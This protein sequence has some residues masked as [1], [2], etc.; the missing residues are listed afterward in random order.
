MDNKNQQIIS[1]EAPEYKHYEKNLGWY[2][3]LIAVA[4]LV[5]GYELLQR[6]F[7][8][9]IVMLI[10]AGFVWF[11]SRQK[12]KTITISLSGKG[13]HLDELQIPYQQIKHFW[14]VN[15]ERHKTLN[16]E[17]TAYLNNLLVLELETQDPETLRQFL[18]RVLPEHAET[19]ETL[20]QKIIHHLKF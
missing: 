13:V 15:N 3:T 5:I 10:L 6:D 12:P 1:W 16:I 14:I 17:T 19:Q 4:I 20:S 11:F 18:L 9:A 7:F 8:A 2:T